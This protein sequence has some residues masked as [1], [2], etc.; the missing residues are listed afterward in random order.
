LIKLRKGRDPT[1]PKMPASAWIL[2]TKDFRKKNPKLKPPTEIMKKA[3]A[4]WKSMA[5]KEKGKYEKEAEKLNSVYKKEIEK[6]VDS[7]KQ[8]LWKRDPNKPKRPLS[9]ALQYMLKSGMTPGP[10]FKK[11][12]ATLAAKKKAAYVK[13]AEADASVYRKAMVEYE[14]SGSEEK[15]K[16]QVGLKDIEDKIEAKAM[17]EKEKA[18]ALK[19]KE[20]AKAMKEKEKVAALKEKAKAKAMKEK[21]KAK[22]LK[23]KEKAKAM[24]EKEKVAALK[25]KAKAKAMKEKEKAK[26]L[27]EKEL[28]AKA[29]AKAKAQKEKEM[30]KVKNLKL[31]KA[32]KPKAAGT[33][34]K[35]VAK[36]TA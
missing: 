2:F 36:V 32:A 26:A 12:W 18:K 19:E 34:A 17:K 4:E 3:A 30:L 35:K 1:R 6:Y 21:E 22:A 14:A 25:E 24:K 27:K 8:A 33:K 5:A 31:K 16:K 23:E 20:K 29:N 10:V 28:K 13:Q 11:A 15:W 9:G 7:G